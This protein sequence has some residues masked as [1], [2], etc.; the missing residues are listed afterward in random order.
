MIS[1]TKGQSVAR[2]M[3]KR[4]LCR[5]VYLTQPD[6]EQ[7]KSWLD[8]KA[9]STPNH[10]HHDKSSIA[11]VQSLGFRNAGKFETKLSCI[12]TLKGLATWGGGQRSCYLSPHGW[13]WRI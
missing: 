1:G 8:P 10:G 9:V 4:R 3:W 6:M 5:S 2:A 7:S 11:E 13:T 12:I